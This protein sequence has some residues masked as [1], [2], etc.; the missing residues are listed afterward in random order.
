L[1]GEKL[2]SSFGAGRALF[3]AVLVA[4][5]LLLIT[6]LNLAAQSAE[7][8]NDVQAEDPFVSAERALVLDG[9]EGE[10]A[11]AAVESVSSIS[12]ILRML[13]VLVLVAAAVYGLVYFIKRFSRR[14][15]IK[16]P[17][18]KVLASAHLGSNRY[19]H[20]VSVG[21]KAWLVGAAEGGVNLITEVADQDALNAMFLEDSRK[22]AEA[23]SG[24]FPDFKT[25]LRRLGVP[26][27]SGVPGA[28]N[29]R[30]RRDRL[31]GL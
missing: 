21:S 4:A 7:Q 28:D 24:R 22:S 31:R 9:D 1:G 6:P 13:L 11:P 16:D 8:Q 19:V 25:M 29:I 12:V 30:K 20:V 5:G 17:F 26:A 10:T 14:S 2:K 18:L 23:A 27:D 3:A 15:E